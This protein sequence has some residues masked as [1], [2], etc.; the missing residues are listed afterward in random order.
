M[1]TD[2]VSN[3]IDNLINLI[4]DKEMQKLISTKINV[5]GYKFGNIFLNKNTIICHTNLSYSAVNLKPIVNGHILVMPKRIV[6]RVSQLHIDELGDIWYLAQQM[7]IMLETKYL[8]KSITFAIQDGQYAGQT[9]DHVHIHIIPRYPKDF[10]KNDD[11]YVKLEKDANVEPIGV[12]DDTERKIQTMEE[13]INEATC[14]KDIID[15][16]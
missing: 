11:I 14:Y 2:L 12:T 10:K 3:K 15:S 5:D 7:S 4:Q 16:M 9:I 1:A 6:P 13:M 8:A